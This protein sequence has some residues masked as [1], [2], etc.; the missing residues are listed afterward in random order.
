MKREESF[1][2]TF[3]IVLGIAIL[4]GAILFIWADKTWG[5]GFILGN[6]TTLFMMSQLNKSSYRIV[7]SKSEQQAQRLAV[8]NYAFRFFFYAVILVVAV[9]HPSF[10]LYA[11]MIGLFIFKIVLYTLGLIEGRGE[12]NN[13]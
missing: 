11:T 2:R 12:K 1:Y 7:E 4:V 5:L 10:N 6:L 8:R 3:P 9:F 13:D